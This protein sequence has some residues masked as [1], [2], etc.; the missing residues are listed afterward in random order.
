MRTFPGCT[1]EENRYNGVIIQYSPA[2]WS[3]DSGTLTR[4]QQKTAGSVGGHLAEKYYNKGKDY[5]KLFQ[6]CV[7]VWLLAFL[8]TLK[9]LIDLFEKGLFFKKKLFSEYLFVSKHWWKPPADVLYRSSFERNLAFLS[10]DLSSPISML[11]LCCV[12]CNPN[13][14]QWMFVLGPILYWIVYLSVSFQDNLETLGREIARLS[15]ENRQL[16]LE[17]QALKKS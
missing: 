16:Q 17:M 2:R 6:H 5:R 1:C 8:H 15:Q 10:K 4:D 3:Y 9:Y 11:I 13:K 14:N 7:M 12:Y